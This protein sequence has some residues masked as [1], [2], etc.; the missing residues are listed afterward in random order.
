MSG[1]LPSPSPVLWEPHLS[2]LMTM[3]KPDLLLG[4]Q[5]GMWKLRG[6]GRWEGWLSESL[7][8]P[9]LLTSLGVSIG[10][11]SES[12]TTEP[13]PLDVPWPPFWDRKLV[14]SDRGEP[15]EASDSGLPGSAV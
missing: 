10:E 11:V 4:L 14:C 1:W 9:A 2:L 8:S 5:S 15:K 7:L 12:G 6:C 13:G 3:L